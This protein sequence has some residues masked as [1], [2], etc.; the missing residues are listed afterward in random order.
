MIR[1]EKSEH[2]ERKKFLSYLKLPIGHNR[3]RAHKRT[4]SLAESSG[5]NTPD[6]LSPHPEPI[7]ASSPLTSPPATPLPTLDDSQL[8]SVSAMRR[9][10]ISQS[11][12]GKDR[13][14]ITITREESTSTPEN[15][16]VTPFDTRTFPLDDDTYDQM[17]ENMPENHQFKTNYRAQDCDF[18]DFD[19]KLMDS[20]GSESTESALGDE[21]PN[22]PE[23]VDMERSRDRHKR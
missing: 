6:P 14:M 22:D 23:W 2:E 21:D 8:P 20:P 18:G 12:F 7:E 5:A 17:L 9:R 16:E 10:T 3:S 19:D 15:I 11:R 4:D 1:H 13:E